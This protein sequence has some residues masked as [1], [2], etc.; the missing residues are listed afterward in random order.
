M[1]M[2][3]MLGKLTTLH[4]AYLMLFNCVYVCVWLLPEQLGIKK[5]ILEGKFPLNM[6]KST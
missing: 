5:W 2:I 6:M 4:Y 1:I 3:S